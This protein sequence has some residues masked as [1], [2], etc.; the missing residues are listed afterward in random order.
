MVKGNKEEERRGKYEKEGMWEVKKDVGRGENKR[1]RS[2]T[3][4]KK[5]KE[6]EHINMKEK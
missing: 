2:E 1:G 5:C 4:G 3:K 6:R